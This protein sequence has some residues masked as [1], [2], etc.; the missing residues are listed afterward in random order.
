MTSC[1]R[2]DNSLS[3]ASANINLENYE[4]RRCGLSAEKR[5]MGVHSAA[6]YDIYEYD[7]LVKAKF[8]YA[9]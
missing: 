4:R 1:S 2:R 7:C 8:H 6:K 5:V 9:S 3:Q